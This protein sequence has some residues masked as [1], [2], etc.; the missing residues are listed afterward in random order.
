MIVIGMM[1]AVGAWGSDVLD[2]QDITFKKGGQWQFVY[3]TVEPEG[4]ADEV[5]AD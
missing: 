4:T 2:R 3:L 5:F 1:A